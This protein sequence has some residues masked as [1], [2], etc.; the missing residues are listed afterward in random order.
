MATEKDKKPTSPAEAMN[1]SEEGKPE[2]KVEKTE[3]KSEA[4]S[5]A[6]EKPIVSERKED[7][8]SGKQE[9]KKSEEPK[10][11]TI[12]EI[13]AERTEG[14]FKNFDD[15][16]KY[17]TREDKKERALSERLKKLADLEEKGIDIYDVLKYDA[18]GYD[19]LNP[20]KP[21]DA[22]ALLFEK[23]SEEEKGITAKELEYKFKRQFKTTVAD[24]ATDEEKEEA[25]IAALSLTRN[26][27]QAQQFLLDKKKEFE[28]PKNNINKTEPTEQEL[29]EL[30]K[31]WTNTV[32]PA[33]SDYKEESFSVIEN[34]EKK[35]YK[36][37]IT[38]EEKKGVLQTM[39]NPSNMIPKL[40]D[41][42]T[43]IN[44]LRRVA[45]I[46]NHF[47][48]ILSSYGEDRF[49]AGHKMGIES[50]ENP[51][52]DV[53]GAKVITGKF[54]SPAEAMAAAQAAGK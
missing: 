50:I 45:L 11:K 1:M 9:E 18:K 13:I 4:T 48:K 47:D 3:T 27:K 16:H 29:S 20:D 52:K 41:G 51:S 43:D 23:W 42:K 32:T 30:V 8:I 37:V 28:L 39:I 34:K 10:P 26:A 40:A 49:N 35:D 25:E 22:K 15:Y 7:V 5:P 12:D 24:D 21:E 31:E 44:G 38:D 6:D 53:R 36:F 33:T 46:Y 2:I 54:N 17:A 14:K 19:K